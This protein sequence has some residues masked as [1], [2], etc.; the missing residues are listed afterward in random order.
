MKTTLFSL[1][2][3]SIVTIQAQAKGYSH[4]WYQRTSLFEKLP[5]STKDIV[6]VGNS[7]TDGGEWCELLGNKNVKN[8]GISGDVTMGVY[9]RIYTITNGKP[10]KIFLLI[11]VNDL[12]GKSSIEEVANNIELIVKKIKNESPKSEIFLQSILPMS[13]EP[14]SFKEHTSRHS[15]VQPLNSLLRNI[16]NNEK[17][18]YIDLYSKFVDPSTGKI[19]LKYSNDGLH[20]MGEGYELWASIVMPYVNR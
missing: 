9:D 5:T 20:L 11:G 19:N 4:Y 16:A 7:I 1:I 17:I 3:L 14:K 15:E 2:L 6:F 12:A 13:D 8:R 10:K 18:T